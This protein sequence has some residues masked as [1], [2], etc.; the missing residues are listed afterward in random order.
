MGAWRLVHCLHLLLQFRLDPTVK[1]VTG[2]CI[3]PFPL[4]VRGQKTTRLPKVSPRRKWLQR[5]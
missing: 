3:R 1:M 4:Q 2:F 5:L